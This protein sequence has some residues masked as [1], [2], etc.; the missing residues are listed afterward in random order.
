MS[1]F[2]RHLR[3]PWSC[4][5]ASPAPWG[6]ARSYGCSVS[7]AMPLPRQRQA[8]GNGGSRPKCQE[9]PA[10]IINDQQRYLQGCCWDEA[11]LSEMLTS[12]F[13]VA[14]ETCDRRSNLTALPAPA[15]SS[16]LTSTQCA[17]AFLGHFLVKVE[18][19][20]RKNGFL[21][22]GKMLIFPN[23][24]KLTVVHLIHP[25]SSPEH[26]MA[27]SF[28]ALHNSLCIFIYRYIRTEAN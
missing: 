2:P 6:T 18:D 23:R 16:P 28:L 4:H 26:W 21:Y 22:T 10:P 13:R 8:P 19:F 12:A 20:I 7:T 25:L 24:P 15:S 3:V 5:G 27:H 14:C 9:F 1:V 11:R 17:T